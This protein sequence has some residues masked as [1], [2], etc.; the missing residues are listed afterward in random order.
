MQCSPN[1]KLPKCL[2][3]AAAA[4]STNA[5][6]AANQLTY[7]NKDRF[8][9]FGPDNIGPPVAL[10]M[11]ATQTGGEQPAHMT[12]RKVFEEESHHEPKY[13]QLSEKSCYSS[14]CSDCHSDDG[15]LNVATMV[16][17]M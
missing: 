2:P 13:T 12:K 15:W 11:H 7:S 8:S 16:G 10:A 14:Q 17:S 4:C 3:A 1:D 9:L 6:W 5:E